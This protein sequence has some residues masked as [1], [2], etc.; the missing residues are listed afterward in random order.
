MWIFKLLLVKS[1]VVTFRF[2]QL[3]GVTGLQSLLKCGTLTA[4]I[5]LNACSAPFCL[6]LGLRMF[7][8]F[9]LSPRSKT[10]FPFVFG[11]PE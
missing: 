8:L 6:L 5:S 3:L 10:I 11:Y 4:V 9:L 2:P 1:Y 7:V